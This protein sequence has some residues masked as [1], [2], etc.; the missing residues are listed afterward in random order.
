D[1]EEKNTENGFDN[2]ERSGM[3]RNRR[4]ARST[5]RSDRAKAVVDEVQAVGNGVEVGVGIEVK[6]AGMNHRDEVKEARKPESDEQVDTQGT[7]DRF[8]IRVIAREDALEDDDNDEDIE[9]KTENDVAHREHA[10][11]GRFQ[12]PNEI[13][14]ASCRERE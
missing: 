9:A 5:K 2:G 13:G 12:Q 7:E 11:I 1:R 14:R 10:R 4:D 8:G 6:G 3:R